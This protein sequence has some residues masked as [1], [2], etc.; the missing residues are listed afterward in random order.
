MLVDRFAKKLKELRDDYPLEN[1]AA[2]SSRAG[3]QR[4][5]KKP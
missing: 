1:W 2:E 4:G 3:E 5:N